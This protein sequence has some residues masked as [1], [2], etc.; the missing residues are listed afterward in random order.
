MLRKLSIL[1]VLALPLTG[2]SLMAG[3][4]K[5]PPKGKHVSLK[6]KLVCLGCDLKSTQGARAACPVYGH[7][8]VLKTGDGQYIN[9]LENRYSED[10]IKG[11]K[12]HGKSIQVE[13]V[14]Y[15]EALT[16]DVETFTVGGQQVGWC[17][18]HKSMD[19]CPF[20]KKGKM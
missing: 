18:G 8:H 16:L 13:G 15:P 20:M 12:Y 10:L 5:A 4:E 14:Y 9:F 1:F 7:K 6:G 19:S 17:D 3:T 2:M 11:E